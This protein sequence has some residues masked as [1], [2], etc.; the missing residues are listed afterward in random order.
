MRSLTWSPLLAIFFLFSI[1]GSIH[2]QNSV[3]WTTNFYAV[4]G[5]NWREIRE[6]IAR[7]RPWTD[8]FDGDTR[9]NITWR[10]TTA[11]SPA[12]CS[13]SSFSTAIRITTTLPRWT[14]P[15][16]VTPSVKEEWTRSF[17]NLAIHEAGHAPIGLAAAVATQNRTAAGGMQPDC[18]Q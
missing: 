5:A 14:P 17:T 12:G 2:A 1:A 10:F 8:S 9:W 18:A 7:A 16:D 6:S 15:P 3:T 11:Q 4:T 13:C